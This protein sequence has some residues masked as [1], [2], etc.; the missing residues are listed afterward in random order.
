MAQQMYFVQVVSRDLFFEE[1]ILYHQKRTW[2]S[3]QWGACDSAH[4]YTIYDDL[5]QIIHTAATKHTLIQQL[6]GPG[7]T[8]NVA[9]MHN[10]NRTI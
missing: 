4:L 6:N 9:S 7:R 5:T 3:W 1:E 2:F 10:E 8:E